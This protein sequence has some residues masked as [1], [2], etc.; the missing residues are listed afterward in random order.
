M[1]KPL[2]ERWHHTKTFRYCFSPQA[3]PAVWDQWIVTYIHVPMKYTIDSRMTKIPTRFFFEHIQWLSSR[4]RHNSQIM[5]LSID[6]WVTQKQQPLRFKL[7]RWVLE[8]AIRALPQFK[9]DSGRESLHFW[10]WRWNTCKTENTITL[11]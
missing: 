2:K 10:L 3:P 9:D 11:Q 7:L 6:F 1:S 5:W 4:T 8:R